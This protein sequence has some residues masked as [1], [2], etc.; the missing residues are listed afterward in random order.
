MAALR[1]KFGHSGYRCDC[2]KA[3]FRCA[4][5]YIHVRLA[6]GISRGQINAALAVQ[7][8]IDY[9]ELNFVLI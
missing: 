2:L 8:W 7:I 1:P 3:V 6:D 5:L 4:N 9:V